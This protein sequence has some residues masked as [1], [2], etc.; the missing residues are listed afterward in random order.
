M[1]FN[2]NIAPLKNQNF[3]ILLSIGTNIWSS[4]CGKK[5]PETSRV[6][7]MD[8]SPTTL[9]NH[10]AMFETIEQSPRRLLTAKDVLNHEG[11]KPFSGGG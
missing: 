3:T 1:T 6:F 11:I 9:M 10:S 7:N 2:L 5:Q 8:W 4:S